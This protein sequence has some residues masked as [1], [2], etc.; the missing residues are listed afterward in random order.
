MNKS[1]RL[2]K[3]NLKDSLASG[4]WSQS[5]DSL[6]AKGGEYRI[7]LACTHGSEFGTDEG[8]AFVE[9]DTSCA[10][11][12]I[13]TVH[14]ALA[15]ACYSEEILVIERVHIGC[16]GPDIEGSLLHIVGNDGDLGFLKLHS[17][18]LLVR[19]SDF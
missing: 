1:R 9:D 2:D 13:G 6:S 10:D 3:A 14:V 7:F 19:Y 15:H 18:F 12:E 4:S 16:K 17:R 8:I 11:S 5:L